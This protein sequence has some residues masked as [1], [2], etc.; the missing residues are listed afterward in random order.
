MT[1]ADARVKDESIRDTFIDCANYCLMAVV[2]MDIEDEKNKANEEEFKDMIDERMENA[3]KAKKESL[4]GIMQTL[5]KINRVRIDGKLE[6]NTSLP[7]CVW[8][9]SGDYTEG[10]KLN[11]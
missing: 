8:K 1:K 5:E 7:N 11:I 6:A 3:E 10:D 4:N 9:S 2:E